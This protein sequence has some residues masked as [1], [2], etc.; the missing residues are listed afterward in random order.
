MNDVHKFHSP[1]SP[2]FHE[3]ERWVTADGSIT[4]VTIVSVKKY[5]GCSTDYTSD[6]EVTYLRD[7]VSCENDCWNFQVRYFHTSNI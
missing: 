6:Y 7:G 1:S 3:G 4:P 5:D 2:A